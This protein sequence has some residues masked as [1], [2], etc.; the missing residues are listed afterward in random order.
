MGVAAGFPL[1]KAQEK[2]RKLS[3]SELGL[4]ADGYEIAA[5]AGPSQ[6]ARQVHMTVVDDEPEAR[7]ELISRRQTQLG[8]IVSPGTSPGN[9]IA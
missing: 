6:V 7:S 2:P 9:R 5:P 3:A 1:P 4:P 8:R